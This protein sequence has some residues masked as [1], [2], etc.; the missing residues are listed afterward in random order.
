[1]A[2][3]N[4]RDTFWYDFRHPSLSIMAFGSIIFIKQCALYLLEVYS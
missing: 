1:M 3:Q 2:I 4:I